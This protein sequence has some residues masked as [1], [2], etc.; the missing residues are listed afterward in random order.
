MK[1]IAFIINPI[2][3]TQNKKKLPKLIAD[4]L[5]P[6]Q[7]LWNIVFT[8]YKGHAI[9]LSRQYAKM[10]FDAV[11]AVGGD[12]TINEVAQGLCDTETSMGILPM[13]SGNGLARHLGI[14]IRAQKAL[15]MLNHSEPIRIDYGMANNRLFVSTCGTGFDAQVAYDFAKA[16]TRGLKTY[17]S[18]V[19][20]DLVG[21]KP[22]TYRIELSNG[23]V[24]EHKAFLLT[25][26][27]SSQ[28]GYEAKI[29][30]RASVQD[31]LMDICM[32]SPQAW[33]GAPSMAIRLFTGN[34]DTS[35]FMDTFQTDDLV[36]HRESET[37]FHIDGDPVRIGKDVH[38]RIIPD[39]LKVLVEKRF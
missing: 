28:W 37:P 4:T 20:K 2:S 7:W 3:G 15:E 6:K 12:G 21:Y 27:N 32:M 33:L 8:E 17:V 25:F 35:L 29:A 38:I 16:G 13:G 18:R 10:G 11:V 26:A 34:L 1:N 14:P 31:G 19:V 22:E 23:E 9:E 5:D 24:V 30:P 36:L 39:G